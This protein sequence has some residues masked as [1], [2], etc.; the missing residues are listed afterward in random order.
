MEKLQK[1]LQQ[2]R[3]QRGPAAAA[4]ASAAPQMPSPDLDAL[5]EDLTPLSTSRHELEKHRIVTSTAGNL[6]SAHDILRTKILLAM[7]KNGWKRIAITSPTMGCGKTTTSCN[8]AIGCARNA[9][10][11]AILLEFDLRRPQ[12][13]K[14]LKMPAMPD[15]GEMLGDRVPFGDQAMR[16]GRNVAISAASKTSVDPTSVLMSKVTHR[17]LGEIETRYQPD[18]MIFDLP[19]IL[20]S[21]DTRAILKDVD[22]AVLIAQAEMTTFAQIDTCEREIAE[23]TNM[24]GVVLNQCRAL[25]EVYGAYGDYYA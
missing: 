5:W 3:D 25:D 24:L 2:A 23:H 18:I 22:C 10:I 20:V 9:D 12:I 15:I 6:G 8:L 13:A 21:D 4:A 14:S 16:Y 7:R 1:A 11:R 17:V 19:P